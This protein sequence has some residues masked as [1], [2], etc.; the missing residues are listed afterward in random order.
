MSLP[1]GDSPEDVRSSSTTICTAINRPTHAVA[2]WHVDWLSLAWLWGFVIVL[3]S[4]CSSGSGSTARLASATGIYPVDSF[5]GY[6]TEQRRPGHA[7]L[8]PV[9]RGRRRLRDRADRRPSRLGTE[10]LM[11]VAAPP[12][13]SYSSLTEARSR[14]RTGRP[15]TRRSR[16]SKARPGIPRLPELRRLRRAPR[17][18]RRARALLHDVGHARAARGLSSS[19]AIPSS[20]CSPT[21]AALEAEASLVMEKIF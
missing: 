3:A 6:T 1:K 13:V 18:G 2:T 19:A 20:G 14:R 5:G 21:S 8:Y 12:F 16:R 7:L 10:V 11:A 15:S 17:S 9:H 4:C